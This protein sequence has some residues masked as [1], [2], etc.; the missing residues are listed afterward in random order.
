MPGHLQVETPLE[1]PEKYLQVG[2]AFAQHLQQHE[3]SKLS[4]ARN[5]AHSSVQALQL[6]TT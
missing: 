4:G 5:K 3:T 1:S 2:Q 6:T